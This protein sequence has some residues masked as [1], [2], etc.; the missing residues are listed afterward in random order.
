MM[1]TLDL[2]PLSLPGFQLNATVSG[3]EAEELPAEPNPPT[4]F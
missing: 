2:P 1:A 3:C 4:D